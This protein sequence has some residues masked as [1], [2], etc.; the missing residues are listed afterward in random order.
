MYSKAA[1]AEKLQQAAVLRAVLNETTDVTAEEES[2][3]EDDDGDDEEEDGEGH[4]GERARIILECSVEEF[5]DLVQNVK[6]MTR[7]SVFEQM[8]V[9]VAISN[10]LFFF[11]QVLSFTPG[12]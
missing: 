5:G 11:F 8:C 2:E 4:W 1:R 7:T 9:I 10:A 3:S 12:H 6:V